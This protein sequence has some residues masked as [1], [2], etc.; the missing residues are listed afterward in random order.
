MVV[1]RLLFAAERG[2]ALRV[3]SLRYM[4]ARVAKGE[5]KTYA[6]GI[7]SAATV[8]AFRARHRELTLCEK[9]CEEAAKLKAD[10]FPHVRKFLDLVAD[11]NETKPGLLQSP[12]RI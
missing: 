11:L 4:M 7:P 5:R 10:I 8:R 6:N 3:N 1:E 9:K 12:N 2:S